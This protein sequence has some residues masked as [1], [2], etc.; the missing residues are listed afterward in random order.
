M[1][2]A[3]HEAARNEGAWAAELD[4]RERTRIPDLSSSEVLFSSSTHGEQV[5]RIEDVSLGGFAVRMAEASEFFAGRE[6]VACFMEG[7]VR[8]RVRYVVA[9]AEGDYRVGLEWEYPR[10]PAVI[11]ILKRCMREICGHLPP[12]SGNR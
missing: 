9:H 12:L 5:G 8:A 4:R 7:L 2:Q 11:D 10:S 3:N 6:L 1:N